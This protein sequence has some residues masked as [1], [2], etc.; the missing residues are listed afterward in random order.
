MWVCWVRAV[1]LGIGAGGSGSAVGVVV[2]RMVEAGVVGSSGKRG[3]R[4]VAT[5][6]ARD[7]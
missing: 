3:T 6:V 2:W 4:D 7:E 1:S 5:G